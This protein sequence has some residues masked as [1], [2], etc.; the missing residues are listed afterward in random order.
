MVYEKDSS[1]ICK[2]KI[3]DC[4]KRSAFK[5]NNGTYAQNSLLT[6]SNAKGSSLKGKKEEMGLHNTARRKK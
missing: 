6:K 5:E 2:V 3:S 1:Y 4:L